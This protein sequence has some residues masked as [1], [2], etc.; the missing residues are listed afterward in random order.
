LLSDVNY[1]CRLATTISAEE[2]RR[3]APELHA[4]LVLVV[5]G[6][7]VAD[8]A[9]ALGVPKNTAWNRLRLGREALD[10]AVRRLRARHECETR[11]RRLRRVH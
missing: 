8:I 1:S 7:A 2:L 5:E 4:V 11:R 6:V 3:T 10:E 9:K